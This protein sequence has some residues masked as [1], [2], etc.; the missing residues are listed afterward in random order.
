MRCGVFPAEAWAQSGKR[1]R[2]PPPG[3][4]QSMA[5]MDS[6][7]HRKP[8]FRCDVAVSEQ[9]A[10]NG[11]FY[12]VK[13][14]K[15]GEFFRFREAERFIASRL[16]GMTSLEEVR[17]S[18]EEKFGLP[19]PP[20]NLRQFINDLEKAGLLTTRRTGSGRPQA[21]RR[22]IRGSL[23]YFR[24][25]FCDPDRLFTR[26]VGRMPFFF[27]PQF[28]VC[29]AAAIL[30]A[31]VIAL[32]NWEGIRGD[33][34]RLYRF[35][36]IPL[37]LLA[38]F[39]VTAIHEFAHGLTCKHFGGEVHEM[40]FLLIYF[41]P[42]LYCNVS[43]A[44]LFR[45]KSKRLWVGFA[46]P[47][48]ELFLWS[49][50]TLLWRVS[51]AESGI[52]YL[53]LIV[54]AGSG[55]KTLFNF[56]PLIKLDGYYLL[57]DYLEIPN[58]RRRAFRYVGSCLK[59]LFGSRPPPAEDMS[60]RERRICLIYGLAASVFS[61]SLLSL[62]VA[63]V[64]GYLA[65]PN[66][67]LTLA[68]FGGLLAVKFRRRLR[69]LFG[70]T[71]ALNDPDDGFDPQETIEQEE[72]VEHVSP[73]DSSDSARSVKRK[74]LFVKRWM[75]PLIVAG[76][77]VFVL[78]LGHC[79]LKIR[80]QFNV[81]PNHI[82]DL[83]AQVEGIV[84]EIYVDE[85][86]RVDP[87]AAVAR[88]S[89]RDLRAERQQ[90]GAQIDQSRAKLRMLEAG[91]TAAEIEVAR[92]AVAKADDCLRYARNRL[93]RDKALFEQDLLSRNDFEAT[94]EQATTAENDVAEAKSKL[95]VLLN[96]SRP[97]E[98]DG[99]RAE[100]ARLEAQQRFLDEQLELLNVTSPI[101]GTVATPSLELTEMKHRLVKKGDLI[102]RIYDC[103]T[104]TAGIVVSEQDIGDVAVGRKVLLK[105]RACPN[106]T[107]QGTVT[108]IATSAQ[109]NS[110]PSLGGGEVL[111]GSPS[112]SR[113]IVTPK[114]VLVT[115]RIDNLSL[116]LKPEMTGQA[117]IYCGQRK[118]FDLV[119]RW[120]ARAV[121][122]EF[123]SW[124]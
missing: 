20:E 66:Q 19:L 107:F 10:A 25:K 24:F 124:W 40:G 121:K 105:A 91:P 22:R 63:K 102:A 79:E 56:N 41:Q 14:P 78:F 114:S 69:R 62:A 58:L 29:S 17:R 94:Q 44:W 38:L 12:V 116:R 64:G 122:V 26:L 6:I 70:R 75:K 86:D 81:L 108:A 60:R 59:R 101:A 48:F 43:D 103:K 1:P 35:S 77:G 4:Q 11:K 7:A 47:Y 99:T 82:A 2:K 89:D 88:L 21:R 92:A 16:D 111:A 61:F 117:K 31:V 49:L 51:D 83:R 112:V 113:P 74:I 54:M 90:A 23:L 3:F 46:G 110:G 93:A 96:G 97:E 55:I 115:T 13:D 42:A 98:I 5:E 65:D 104:V 18:A 120:M 67:P 39:V 106:E 72:S 118:L 33:I 28:L 57:G 84:E 50:A 15:S 109:I 9:Q 30:L 76:V 95:K 80:G 36:A 8:M 34:S 73:R 45:E 27:T 52:N 119:T 53:A 71:S 123:W 68:L 32:G 100:I 87:G 85:G 37:I